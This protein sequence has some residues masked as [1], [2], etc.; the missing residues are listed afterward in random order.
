MIVVA[1]T[2][3]LNYLVLIR[4]ADLLFRLFGRVLIPPAVF[5]ELQDAE[6]PEE[7]RSWLARAPSWLNVQSLRSEPDPALQHLDSGEREAIMLAEELRA[8]YILLDEGDARR[9]ASRR[10]LSFI[11]TLGILRRASQLDL[12]DLP[13]TLSRLQETTFYVDP[14]LIQ[15]LLDEDAG[16]RSR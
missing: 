2:T 6:T 1:D 12:I 3:P 7:V 5:A 16:R 8:D 13:S 11:G 10:K 15:S 14:R 4:Q 9:E